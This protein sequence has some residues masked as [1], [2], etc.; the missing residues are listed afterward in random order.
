MDVWI[1]YLD[2]VPVSHLTSIDTADVRY[3]FACSYDE[4]VA[5]FTTGATLEMAMM[6]AA[7]Q[8]NI[9]DVNNGLGNSG[10]KAK[11]GSTQLAELIDVVAFPPTFMGRIA[12]MLA[13][14]KVA[15][16]R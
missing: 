11:W 9:T 1:M 8:T 3:A 7:T 4:K 10:Y 14:L 13:R 6:K 12:H 16:G 5:N 15:L 2:G